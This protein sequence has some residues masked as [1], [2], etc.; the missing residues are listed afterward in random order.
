M[1][2]IQLIIFLTGALVLGG[3]FHPAQMPVDGQSES[4][5]GANTADNVEVSNG[6]RGEVIAGT[7]TPLLDFNQADYERALIEYPFVFLYFYANWCP[8]CRVET[9]EALYPAFDEL[10]YDNVIGFRVNFKDSGTDKDEQEIARKYAVP[11]QHY[12]MILKN[13]EPV[14]TSNQE[15]TKDDYL[16]NIRNSIEA[17]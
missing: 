6:Y 16:M 1:K 9:V 3:C 4:D 2:L 7:T 13:G 15:W 8:I 10:D 5:Q 14:L 11:Y 12:K 17:N